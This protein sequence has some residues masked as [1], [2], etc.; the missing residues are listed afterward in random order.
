M[1]H[2]TVLRY[3]Q[4][5]GHTHVDK[6]LYEIAQGLQYLHSR[7]IVHGDLR[8]VNI[9]IQEDW[10]A[11]LADFGLS[12]FSDATASVTSN[13][14]GSTYWMAPELLAPERF[15]GS[16]SRTPASDV[17]AFACVCIELYTGRPPWGNI[18]EV[19]VLWKVHN[20]ERP[21]RPSNSPAMSDALWQHVSAYWAENPATRPATHVVLQDMVWPPPDPRLA[22]PLPIHPNSPLSWRDYSAPALQPKR[23]GALRNVIPLHT[24]FHIY[25]TIRRLAGVPFF[26]GEFAVSWEFKTAKIKGTGKAKRASSPA[27]GQT[28]WV[29]LRDGSATW[30]HSLCGVIQM[31]IEHDTRRL[32]S[33]PFKLIV[34]Q[35][36]I[37][38]GSNTA[39]GHVKVNL[40]EYTDSVPASMLHASKGIVTPSYLLQES[41]INATLQFSIRVEPVGTPPLFTAPPLRATNLRSTFPSV[42]P[43]DYFQIGSAPGGDDPS[44]YSDDPDDYAYGPNNYSNDYADDLCHYPYKAKS[45]YAYSGSADDPN[46][47]SFKKGEILDIVDKQDKWWLARKADGTS[48]IVPSDY[49]EIICT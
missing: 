9:L 46:E 15:G 39:L 16:S 5:H 42:A 8:G 2:G 45:L 23:C 21:E 14:A 48:G 11:C 22:H 6:L 26:Q 35:Q 12:A 30:E 41:K 38:Y 20:G 40:A 4:D 47:L 43:S 3:L 24:L 37:W 29:P 28:Y 10:S 44:N 32:L 13:R 18:A 1:E 33:H 17:Y 19:V 36:N 25:I 31:T 27:C 34:L 49:L 7:G